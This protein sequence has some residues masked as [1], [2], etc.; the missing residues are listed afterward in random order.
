MLALNNVLFLLIH[1]N[2]Y[3]YIFNFNTV[4]GQKRQFDR[5]DQSGFES[6]S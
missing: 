5:S 1:F 2:F 6:G 3:Y 4:G